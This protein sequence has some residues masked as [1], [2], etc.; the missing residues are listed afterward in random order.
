MVAEEKGVKGKE[1]RPNSASSK[2]GADKN[3]VDATG[4]AVVCIWRSTVGVVK[5]KDIRQAACCN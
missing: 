2:P 5:E 1:T 3:I 4:A